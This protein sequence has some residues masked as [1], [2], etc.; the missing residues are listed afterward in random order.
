[1]F[2]SRLYRLR[3]SFKFIQ[4]SC[5]LV[6]A[7]TTPM[8]YEAHANTLPDRADAARNVDSPKEIAYPAELS[9]CRPLLI[10]GTASS[11]GLVGKFLIATDPRQRMATIQITGAGPANFA[12]GV[13]GSRAWV[14]GASGVVSDADFD[15]Y[16]A[17]I[18]SDAYWLSGG[19]FNTCWPANIRF[20]RTDR[21][22]GV[23][24]DMLTVLPQG[25]K[26][27]TAWVSQATHL[28]LRWS[29]R[30]EPDVATTTYADYRHVDN[31]MIPFTQRM[32]DRDGNLWN[33]RD[34]R[35]QAMV[36]PEVVKTKVEKPGAVLNDYWID[37][38]TSTTIP[39][40]AFDTPH[41]DVFIN[42]RGPFNFLFD[43]G[44]ALSITPATAKAAGLKLFGEGR[45]TGVTGSAIETRFAR[46]KDLRLGNAHIQDQYASIGTSGSDEAD[47]QIAGSIGYEVLARF[48]T[49]FDFPRRTVTL[50]TEPGHAMN[51]LS[52]A[53][54]MALD[55][56]IPAVAGKINGVPDYFWL[57]TGFNGALLV[58]RTFGIAHPA[59]MPKRLY[60]TGDSLSGAGGAGAIKLGRISSLV[61]GSTTF[62]GPIGM[63]SSFDSGPNT[64]SEF[65]ADVGDA[66]FR[67]GVLTFDYRARRIWF[68]RSGSSVGS[69]APSYN[70][71]GFGIE[72][73]NDGV[74]TISY[75]R[76]GSP[77]A[78]AGL[79]EGDH[80][81]E[82]NGQG[83]SEQLV[84]ATKQYLRTVSDTALKLA[85]LRNGT[86]LDFTVRPRDYIQ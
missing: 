7:I 81:I 39:M 14:R 86:I 70:R 35:V 79:Q 1:M 73:S 72:Y 23:R 34:L 83:I 75:V 78:E 27:T 67:H 58:N 19:I 84:S 49:T 24:V 43:T 6:L 9:N 2:V 68:T 30:D 55:H 16:R 62:V 21:V 32:T 4:I 29:R 26:V 64:D 48:T 3:M 25:G 46:I 18:V 20:L 50:S 69:E 40:G 15:G 10:E 44:G 53:L 57:D 74:A 56:T 38:G 80:V 36:A 85:V 13:S 5:W 65:A 76:E 71:A 37:G 47:P 61:I 45:D 51:D 12:F 42:G 54:P 8:A 52:D 17:G 28:P 82:V 63:F 31:R 77:A 60:D 33:L 59:A 66:L 11:K 41:V 22:N